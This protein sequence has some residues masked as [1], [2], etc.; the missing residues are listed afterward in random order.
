M[1]DTGRDL[2]Q[3]V[4][5]QH[6]RGDPGSAARSASRANSASRAPRSSP[7]AGSSMRSSS[8]PAISARASRTCWRSPSDN[9]PN[10]RPAKAALPNPTRVSR[11]HRVGPVLLGVLVPPRLERGVASGE[12]DVEGGLLGPQGPADRGADHGDALPEDAHVDPAQAFPQ[13]L[14]RP[15]GRPEG[16]GQDAQQGGLPRAVGPSSAHRSPAPTVQLTPSRMAVPS[17]TTD[18]S[19]KRTAGT[20]WVVPHLDVVDSHRGSLG[21]H[22]GPVSAQL[23]PGPPPVAPR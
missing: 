2:L 19:R 18:T 5:H 13:D 11:A 15:P 20:R 17:R 4:G 6:E 16:G 8:G 21:T 10:G 9:R 23:R 14:D 3:V 7:A 22:L 12:H 1:G